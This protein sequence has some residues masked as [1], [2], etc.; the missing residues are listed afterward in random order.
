MP[1]TSFVLGSSA[2]LIGSELSVYLTPALRFAPPRTPKR[3][4]DSP[5]VLAHNTQRYGHPLA[6]GPGPMGAGLSGSGLY[7]ACIAGRVVFY[8][9]STT[10]PSLCPAPL[11]AVTGPVAEVVSQHLGMQPS[12]CTQ[13]QVAGRRQPH[14]GR[15]GP[16]RHFTPA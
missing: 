10:R 8:P 16:Q 3:L 9:S 2:S 4:R 5:A 13:P 12:L 7:N 1:A 6:G 15:A 14:P 11:Q